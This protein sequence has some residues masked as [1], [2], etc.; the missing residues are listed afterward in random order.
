MDPNY[1]HTEEATWRCTRCDIDVPIDLT[2]CE[3]CKTRPTADTPVALTT[4]TAM[5]W[6]QYLRTQPPGSPPQ[7]PIWVLCC[8]PDPT[9]YDGGMEP[10]RGHSKHYV[11]PSWVVSPMDMLRVPPST[12]EHC[13]KWDEGKCRIGHRCTLYH[14]PYSLPIRYASD[15]WPANLAEATATTCTVPPCSSSTEACTTTSTA[16]YN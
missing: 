12:V 11:V 6:N 7:L 16:C 15:T 4:T 5:T 8:A 13:W 9:M 1:E 10:N 14:H 2:T 3:R